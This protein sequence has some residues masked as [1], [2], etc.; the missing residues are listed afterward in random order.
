MQ[1]AQGVREAEGS[2]DRET[3]RERQRQGVPEP[4]RGVGQGWVLGEGRVQGLLW[5]LW[6]LGPWAQQ[7]LPPRSLRP[8]PWHGITQALGKG[9]ASF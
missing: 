6:F 4:G 1:S 7:C 8:F 2:R 3:D 9:V 5:L